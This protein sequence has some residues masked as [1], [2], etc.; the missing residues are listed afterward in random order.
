MTQAFVQ[1]FSEQQKGAL[2]EVTSKLIRAGSRLADRAKVLDAR[3][4]DLT[5]K[6]GDLISS[7]HKVEEALAE[8]RE[9]QR[10]L[11]KEMYALPEPGEEQPIFTMPPSTN[12]VTISNQ[13]IAVRTSGTISR[14]PSANFDNVVHL[15]MT[16]NLGDLEQSITPILQSQLAH[17]DPCGE[18]VAI[19]RAMV[20]TSSP[21][22]DVSGPVAF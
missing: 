11:G 9:Q 4:A 7:S 3:I 1:G 6:K 20:S 19:Q 15:Q 2:K 21:T 13:T 16:A 14:T 10:V 18:Q 8:F 5:M 12:S 17:S 22:T